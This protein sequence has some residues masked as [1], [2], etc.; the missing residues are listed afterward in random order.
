LAFKI[1]TERGL[2]M[3][4]SHSRHQADAV[5]QR[6]R[7]RQVRAAQVRL[8]YDNASTGIVVTVL[9]APALGYFQWGVNQHS[10]VLVWLMYMLLV[11]AA[12]FIL[13]RRYWRTS[14][15]HM[16]DSRWGVAFA[17]G[18][19]MAAAGWGTAGILLYPE[20]RGMNQIFLVFVLG[21]MMLGGASLLAAR[22]EAFLAFLLP[23]GLLPAMRL[24]FEGDEEHL[25]MGLLALLFTG[26]TLMTT[27]RFYR[28]IESSLNLGFDKQDL[29]E[30]LQVA[31][32]QTEL[33]NRD[34]ELRVRERT[35]ELQDSTERL[36]KEIT[37]REGMEEEL[38]RVR[39]LESLGVLA[40]GIAHDFNNFLTVVQGSIEV[41]KLRLDPDAPV[42]E[43]LEQAMVA[44]QRAIF[45]S[46]QL[47]TFAKGGAPILR[48]LPVAPLI[49]DAVQ[50]AR[51]GSAVRIDVDVADDLWCAEVDAAQIGQVFHNILLNAKQATEEQGVIEVRAENVTLP[52]PQNL[53]SG[54]QVR[55][56]IRDYGCGIAAEN[57]PFVFDP[58]FTTK[59]LGNGFGLATAHAIV[60]KHG[61]RVSVESTY[62]ESTTFTVDLPACPSHPAPAPPVAGRLAERGT[63]TI[64]VMDD[65]QPVRT[66][67]VH[68]LTAL[69]Y[70]VT[71]ASDGAEAIAL[72]EAAEKAGRGVDAALLDLTV[73]GGMGGV[74]AA[75]KLKELYPSATLIASS[76][77]SNA[78]VMSNHRKYAFDD[79]LPK[80][81]TMA[82]LSDVLRRVLVVDHERKAD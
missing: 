3:F 16:E 30:N 63:G 62:G 21:G 11:A 4:S 56:S 35:A 55:V 65:E 70:E 24:L 66:L 61:G 17:V 48:I 18:A 27:W 82:Q 81:W 26:A 45:L 6:Q 73:S 32:N 34:L 23:T 25:V 43:I 76:G 22:S 71:S 64:L 44:C 15:S 59:R 39:K 49:E 78:P 20:A 74:E 57:L 58:Y 54:A 5:A 14:P 31:N 9:A 52:A 69:G 75:S 12:R 28:A 41:I 29:L 47:L 53:S 38:L 40:G 19:G 79:V 77:Y 68:V 7:T 60:S 51:A 33:L 42:R 13:A 67:L 80:P 36:R 8:L 37:Q 72:Y 10:V 50:L 1:H 46:S 2:D